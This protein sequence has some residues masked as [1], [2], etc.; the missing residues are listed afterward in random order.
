MAEA[1]AHDAL[2]DA[3][4]LER[5]RLGRSDA[6]LV[7]AI[8]VRLS[9]TRSYLRPV[10]I[11]AQPFQPDGAD[12][13]CETTPGAGNAP[14]RFRSQVR[15]AGQHVPHLGGSM[16]NPIAP[17][18]KIQFPR[19]FPPPG[20]GRWRQSFRVPSACR[21]G[22]MK[23]GDDLFAVQSG[24]GLGEAGRDRSGLAGHRQSVENRAFQEPVRSA[25]R[26]RAAAGRPA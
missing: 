11:S 12:R 16:P 25:P 14:K 3:A 17:W 24:F 26:G 9:H 19:A 4:A 5:Q 10:L 1:L 6:Q 7:A 18:S 22:G 13:Q 8:F 2:L 15:R 21:P 20:G 23:D